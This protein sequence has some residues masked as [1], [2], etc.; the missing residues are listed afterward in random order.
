[1]EEGKRLDASQSFDTL[2]TQRLLNLAPTFHYL[3]FLKVGN[4]LAFRR[5]HGEATALPETGFL[6]AILTF[7]HLGCFLSNEVD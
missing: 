6:A 7:S 5:L 4:E 1:M 2:R 3:H